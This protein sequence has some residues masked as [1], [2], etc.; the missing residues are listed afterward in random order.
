MFAA[1]RSKYN[2]YSDIYTNSSKLLDWRGIF[3]NSQDFGSVHTRCSLFTT[4]VV[5]SKKSLKYFLHQTLAL[6]SCSSTNPL[7][8]NII[9]LNLNNGSKYNREKG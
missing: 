9:D 7:L 4:G 5:T 2:S 3:H 1:Y 6:E 8:Q